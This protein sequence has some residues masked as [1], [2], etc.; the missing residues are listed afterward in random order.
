M[1]FEQAIIVRSKTRLEQLIER[2]NTKAQAEFYIER[3]GGEFGLYERE[4]KQ[5][6]AVLEQ[7][8]SLMDVFDVYKVLDRS[9]LPSYVFS[10]NDLIIVL[11]QDG[12]V[13][14]AAKYVMGLPMVAINPDP[15]TYDGILL[16]F[17]VGRFSKELEAIKNGKFRI[18]NITMAEAKFSDGQTLLA[19]NDFFIGARSHV[20]ARYKLKFNDFDEDQSSS[21]ILVS[22]GAGSTGWMSSVFNMVNGIHNYHVGSFS[23]IEHRVQWEAD[24]LLFAV[25]EPFLSKTSSVSL[26]FGE[27]PRGEYLEIESYMPDNGIVFSDGIEADAV[28][29]TTGISV[30]IGIANEI[31]KLVV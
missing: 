4:H 21:G 16:P 17:D 29:F 7:L 6:Y 18:K 20:S 13:A 11:G 27:I 3:S 24:Q 5:F 31:A 30:K 9:F 2:F 23:E 1:K 26:C 22:T 15:G 19:F 12:L 14:N 8:I 28:R 10:E 25:R